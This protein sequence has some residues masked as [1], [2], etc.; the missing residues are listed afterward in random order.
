RGNKEYIATVK[1]KFTFIDGETGEEI[2]I[3]SIGEGQD[4]GDKA[5]YKA[6][7]GATKYA[8]M[9]VFM[10]PTGDDPEQDYEADERNNTQQSNQQAPQQNNQ[11]VPQQ[12]E[13]GK[14]ILLAKFKQGGKTEEEFNA[15]YADQLSKGYNN[16][17]IDQIL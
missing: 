13:V 16:N 14:A 7:T 10:I 3:H 17:Q 1:M 9:K 11:Q 12:K 6:I 8:L 2:S 15:W 5:V 4:A